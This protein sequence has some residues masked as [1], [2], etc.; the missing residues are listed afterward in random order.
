M[1]KFN[2]LIKTLKHDNSKM[3]NDRD[4]NEFDFFDGKKA[5]STYLKIFLNYIQSISIVL[6]L[7]M[8]FPFY[9]K[10]YFKVYSIF[11]N[12]SSQTI[13]F[14]CFLQDYQI[15]IQ[16]IYFET[17]FS[18]GLPYVITF[19]SGFILIAIF[20]FWKK[21]KFEIHKFVA[22][23]IVSSIFLQPTIITML[24]KNMVCK[25][26]NSNS[27]LTTNLEIDCDSYSHKQWY[28]SF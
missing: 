19:S 24:Y 6:N 4:F 15:N 17:F 25:K 1:Q 26:L 27:L 18:I 5:A 23:I 20:Y 2:I 8:K 7:G 28:I 11:G 16:A 14:D 10:E 9:A 22:I 12:V 3:L 13:S 21:K